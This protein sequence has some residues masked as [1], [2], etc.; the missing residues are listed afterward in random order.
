MSIVTH[1]VEN[2]VRSRL[3]ATARRSFAVGALGVAILLGRAAPAEAALPVHP[4]TAELNQ[5]LQA[6]N[7]SGFEMP[8]KPSQAIVHGRDGRVSSGGEVT[9]MASQVRQ[10]IADCQHSDVAAVQQRVA[11][12]SEK[13]R[14]LS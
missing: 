2:Q 14:Q 13:L 1:F 11:L 5:L 3:L 10:A 6:W 9:Y 4:C 7:E 12:L 8:S